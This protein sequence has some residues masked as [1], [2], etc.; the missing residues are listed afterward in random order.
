[1]ARPPGND[2]LARRD[3]LRAGLSLGAQLGLGA[4]LQAQNNRAA[5]RPQ[6]GDLLVKAGDSTATPLTPA[7]IRLAGRQVMAWAMDPVDKTV[8][9]G[10]R[11]NR[12]LVVRP[13]PAKLNAGTKAQ[14]AEGV[15]AYSA[16]CTH[17]GCEVTE[18]VP[19]G[20]KLFC[21]C[22]E[23]TFDP[24]DDAKVIDGPA[25]RMLPA[26]ALDVSDGKLIVREPFTS[27]ITFETQ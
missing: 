25:T 21:P 6:K 14:S 1:M 10:S 7:D 22:H 11:L 8:R 27:P 16:I 2:R 24:A 23:S 3:I 9:S 18:W 13:D 4:G 20:Q 17:A 12:I 15:V 26:L 19:D 5:N